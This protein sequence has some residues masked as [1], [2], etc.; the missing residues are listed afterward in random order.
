[1]TVGFFIIGKNYATPYK[2]SKKDTNRRDN[3][4]MIDEVISVLSIKHIS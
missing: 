4:K 1:M 2:I 3:L